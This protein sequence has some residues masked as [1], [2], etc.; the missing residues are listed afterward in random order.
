MASP[1]PLTNVQLE[2]L[3]LLCRTLAS[4][5]SLLRWFHAL[6]K[7]PSNLRSNAIIQIT[8]EMRRGDEDPDLIGAI[9]CLSDPA[10][11]QAASTAVR[12]LSR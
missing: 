5:K 2:A 9:C 12:Q 11:Y 6:E 4:E 3:Q 7:L 10:V 8:G 1:P